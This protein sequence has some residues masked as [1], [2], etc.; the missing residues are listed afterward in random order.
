M[1]KPTFFTWHYPG[2]IDRNRVA[3][4]S[5]LRE[6]LENRVGSDYSLLISQQTE[7]RLKYLIFEPIS[8]ADYDRTAQQ[9]EN[10]EYFKNDGDPIKLL[11]GVDRQGRVNLKT[12]GLVT[13]L[14]SQEGRE[15]WFLGC[16]DDF[17][18]HKTDKKGL[19]GMVGLYGSNN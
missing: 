19:R 9:M 1:F 2:S 8:K 4:P 17:E 12:S 5:K 11:T 10:A 7:G 6:V 16:G 14:N 13:F 18:L 3:L 15:Y